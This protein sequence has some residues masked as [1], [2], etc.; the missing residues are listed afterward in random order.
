MI[1]KCEEECNNTFNTNR[2]QCNKRGLGEKFNELF[3]QYCI[4]SNLCD[5][6]LAG[7]IMSELNN[8]MKEKSE[9]H[10]RVTENQVA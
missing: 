9:E 3:A 8:S 7:Q 6:C 5:N 4:S 2:K 1:K 10:N